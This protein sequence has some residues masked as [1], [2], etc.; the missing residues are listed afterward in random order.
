[1]VITGDLFKL[2]YLGAYRPPPPN[3]PPVTSGSDAIETEARTVFKRAV[4]ILL[5]C[6]LVKWLL[7]LGWPVLGNRIGN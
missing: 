7:E 5:E 1:M 4:C 6:C 3:P 2:V